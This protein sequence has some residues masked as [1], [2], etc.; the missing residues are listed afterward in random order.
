MAA[1]LIGPLSWI[2]IYVDDLAKVRPFYEDVLGLELGDAHDEFANYKTGNCTLELMART[3]NA[4]KVDGEL[5]PQGPARVLVS[6]KIDSMETVVATLRE[7][8]VEPFHGPSATVSPEGQEPLGRVVQYADPE[9]NIIEF[10]DEAL[11][12]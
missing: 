8:G 12:V 2:L 9:G 1:P 4:P 7:R 3:D 10:C 5:R 6:F 11:L